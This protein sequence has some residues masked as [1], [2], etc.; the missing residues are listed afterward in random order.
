MINHRDAVEEDRKQLNEWIA[1]SPSTHQVSTD[2]WIN[3][4]DEN[5]SLKE[6]G[7]KTLVIEDESGKVFHLRVEN[8]MRVY[9]QFPPDTLIDPERTKDALMQSFKT[10]AGNGI[11]LGY[12][13]M[14]FD[15]TA[16]PLIRFFK[17]FGF[18]KLDDTFGVRL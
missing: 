13:E 17:K 11:R 2:F 12:K 6:L 1:A 15:S 5:G 9:V 7:V 4:R 18:K 16:K 10:I 3:K 14:L 8:V